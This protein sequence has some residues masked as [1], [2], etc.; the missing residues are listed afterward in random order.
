M[1]WVRDRVLWLAIG[2]AFLLRAVPLLVWAYDGCLRDECTYLKI[3]NR[4]VDGQ[5]ITTSAGWLWAPGYPW[6]LS[7]HERVTGQ[8]AT[9]KATQILVALFCMILMYRLTLRLFKESDDPRRV[10]RAAV[11][12]YAL[13]PHLAFFSIR[14]W[15][16][17]VY[18]TILMG[19]LLLLEMTRSQWKAPPISGWPVVVLL[20]ILSCASVWSFGAPFWAA[21]VFGALF[22][23]LVWRVRHRI[24][25]GIVLA[26]GVGLLAGICVLF[27]GVATYMLPIL[28]VGLLWGRLRVIRSWAQVLALISAAGLVI[29]PY[30]R[31]A[32]EKF[33]D[34][35]VS[36]RTMGQMMWLGNNDYEPITFDYGNGQLSRRAF[37]RTT[38][39]GRSPCADRDEAIARDECQA[40]AG[41]DWI[42]ANPVA[43]AE[44]M[45]VRVAQ[46]VNPHSLLTRHLR[47]GRWR[48]MPQWLDEFIIMFGAL[49]SLLVMVGGAVGLAARARSGM[50]LVFNGILLYHVA[51]IAALAGLSRYR[52]PLEPLL[53]IYAA[54]L[55]AD[56]SGSMRR[57][58]ES[59]LRAWITGIGLIL[60]VPLVLWYLPAGWPWWRSW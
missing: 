36:D 9:M 22:F 49:S 12:L 24:P 43:F 42:R 28:V 45:P 14:L 41:F 4:F 8:A 7:L 39:T 21:I 60:F 58:R 17:V 18:G 13:S 6:L 2:V 34:T 53:M 56:W 40:E 15:S 10:A 55:Y 30:S 1:E 31:H 16:E 47:W 20:A 44:R 19:A 54:A 26:G 3:S 37:R 11:W 33:G 59:R 52:V 23:G 35:V 38:Q 32:S 46:L 25:K 48:G 5:G 51:A 29:A 50:G 57:L 27:R